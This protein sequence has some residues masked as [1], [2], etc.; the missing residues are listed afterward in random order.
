MSITSCGN[1]VT[2]SDVVVS[3]EDEEESNSII[4]STSFKKEFIKSVKLSENSLRVIRSIDG[5]V[6]VSDVMGHIRFYDKELKI[7]FWCPSNESIDSIITISFDLN[8]TLEFDDDE[9]TFSIRDFFVRK[10][11]LLCRIAACKLKFFFSFF[12][13][14]KVTFSRLMCRK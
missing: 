3:F 6:M 10:E 12:Q 14:P 1:V 4:T 5:F 9:K 13:K 2:W 8:R 7:L 11:N